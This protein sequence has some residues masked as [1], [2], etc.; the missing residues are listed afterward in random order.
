MLQRAAEVSLALIGDIRRQ[1]EVTIVDIEGRFD[2]QSSPQIKS[3]LHKLIEDGDT[4]LVLNLEKMDFSN[5]NET[6]LTT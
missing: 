3:Q 4:R 6:N 5:W 1:D 2:A